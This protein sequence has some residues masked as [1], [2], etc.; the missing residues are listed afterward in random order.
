MLINNVLFYAAPA[1]LS[2]PVLDDTT[3]HVQVGERLQLR[4]EAIGSPTPAVYLLKNVYDASYYNQDSGNGTAKITVRTFDPVELKDAGT[5]V[6]L[7]SNYL[8]GP[9]GGKRKVTD[10]KTTRVKV[11]GMSMFI[12]ACTIHQLSRLVLIMLV[13][14][15]ALP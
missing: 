4:C 8:V 15:L 1:S 6:C 7:A 12:A 10:W 2:V 14:Y 13:T 9:P 5:Y 3:I 11:T